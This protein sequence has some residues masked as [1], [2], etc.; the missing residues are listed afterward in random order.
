MLASFGVMEEEIFLRV[1]SCLYLNDVSSLKKK[2]E[3]KEKKLT[4]WCNDYNFS[5]GAF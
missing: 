3:K 2:N 5:P 1:L 4:N